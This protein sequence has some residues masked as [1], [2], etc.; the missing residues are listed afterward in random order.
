MWAYGVLKANFDLESF[1]CSSPNIMQQC[2]NREHYHSLI[3]FISTGGFVYA[4]I[5]QTMT[6]MINIDDLTLSV[7]PVNWLDRG[8]LSPVK[9]FTVLE[10]F[11]LI[12]CL[13]LQKK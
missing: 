5:P 13:F 8:G 6:R 1:A 2:F 7:D 3:A 4:D 9:E 10:M 12:L 11:A